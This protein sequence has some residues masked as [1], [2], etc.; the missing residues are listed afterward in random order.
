MPNP[1]QAATPDSRFGMVNVLPDGYDLHKIPGHKWMSLAKDA[2]VR[3]NRWEFR[4][5]EIQ[6]EPGPGSWATTDWIVGEN[7]KAQMNLTGVLIATPAWASTTGRPG[8]SVPIGLDEPPLL[9]DGSPNP[10]NTFANFSYWTAKRYAGRVSTWQVWNEPNFGQFWLGS[11]FQYY[12]LLKSAYIAIKA[13]DP[14]ANV[15]FGA[16]A[17]SGPDYLKEVLNY[18]AA[19][20]EAAERKGFFDIFI[21]H[22]YTRPGFL[23]EYTH[24]YRAILLAYGWAK[25]IWLGETGIPAWDDPLVA[26]GTPRAFGEASTQLEQGYFV[27][28]AI[29][30]ALAAGADKVF[31]YRASDVGEGRSADGKVIPAWGFTR[32]NGTGRPAQT[33]YH[34]MA[35]ALQ[36]ATLLQ[37][38]RSADGYDRFSFQSPGRVVHVV[39]TTGTA[40]KRVSFPAFLG[41]KAMAV[42]STGKVYPAQADNKQ[43]T[44][45]LPGA[46][47]GNGTETMDILVAGAPLLVI[48]GSTQGITNNNGVATFTPIR[49]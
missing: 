10:A 46:S 4:W 41:D 6:S 36:G 33:A 15:A 17:G 26:E 44:V 2:G 40:A 45:E 20:P 28:Q 35:T 7:A 38:D 43:F 11:T 42:D 47:G 24:S 22:G 32:L 27:V 3:S 18:I 5:D 21:W 14:Q 39:F 16:I 34:L 12:Q 13:A 48:E 8:R 23:F 1:A 37:T 30:Y 25:P 31:F 9:A 19:D 29:T 49:N